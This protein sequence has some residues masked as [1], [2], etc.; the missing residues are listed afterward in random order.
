MA[1]H[2]ISHPAPAP[3][4]GKLVTPTTIV[5]FLLSLAAAGVMAVRLVYGL[6]AVANINDG[7]PWGIWIAYDLVIGSAL[8]CGGFAISLL[9]YIL[10]RGEYHP[11]I[12]PALLASL[13]GYTLAGVS[14]FFDIG[15]YWN[16]WHIMWPGYINVGSVMFELATCMSAYVLVMFVEFSPA[17]TE[18][19]GL[20]RVGKAVKKWTFLVV[21]LGIVLPTMHQS[22]IG[23]MIIVFGTQIDPLWRTINL[24]LLFLMSCILMGYAAV[25]F[26]ACLSSMGFKRPMEVEILARLSKYMLGLLAGYL[27]VRFADLAWHG[28]LGN[29]FVPGLKS[30]MFWLE[31]ALYVVPLVLL[32]SARSR[33]RPSRLF[34]AAVFMAAAGF[35]Y[36]INCFLIG[37]DTGAGW[38]YFPSIWEVTFSVG[39]IAFEILA[40]IIAVRTLPILTPATERRP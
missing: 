9:I 8:A 23:A 14:I 1:S 4:G 39:I 35:V 33:A 22:S 17:L 15:R 27:V 11:L 16:F 10:N 13:A 3:L 6:G 34:L 28:A 26:E 29:A 25:I 30:T 40:Y 32:A 5:L 21:A 37:Y 38:H 20:P 24:P 18:R 31:N 12:R 7:Y 2:A 36:R 19:F